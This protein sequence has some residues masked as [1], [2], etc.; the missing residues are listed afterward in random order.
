MKGWIWACECTSRTAWVLM[1]R[2]TGCPQLTAIGHRRTWEWKVSCMLN[3]RMGESWGCGLWQLSAACPDGCC[4]RHT[5]VRL[6]HS[7]VRWQMLDVNSAS[8]NSC[9]SSSSCSRGARI[10][11]TVSRAWRQ[12][13]F[14]ASLLRVHPM[15]TGRTPPH[16]LV[17]AVNFAP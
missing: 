11:G 5:E 7:F 6:D 16:L 13:H 17:S 2:L 1:D 10:W 3:I 15:A 9:F 4:W 14:E 12:E 8:V